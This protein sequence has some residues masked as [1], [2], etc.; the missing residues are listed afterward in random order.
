MVES[1]HDLASPKSSPQD[2]PDKLFRLCHRELSSEWNHQGRIQAREPHQLEFFLEAR[3]WG[4]RAIRL[5]H[6]KWM[7]IKGHGKGREAE[8]TG[9]RHCGAK[10]LLMAPMDP[11]EGSQGRDT[12]FAIRWVEIEAAEN[13]HAESVQGSDQMA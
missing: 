2:F 1:H 10:D 3:D 6:L 5:K 12:L 9:P 11:I 8:M 4:R 13:E 7:W